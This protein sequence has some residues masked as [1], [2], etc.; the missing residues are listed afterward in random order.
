MSKKVLRQQVRDILAAISAEHL[1]HRS[2]LACQLL[3]DQE[4]YRRAQTLM[5]FLSTTHEVDT[6]QL[7]QRAW[8]DGKTVLAPRVTW[9]QRRMLPIEIQSLGS[10]VEEGYMGI[11]EPAEGMPVPVSELDLVIVPGLAFDEQGNRLGRGRGFYDRF[12]AHPDFRGIACAL[13]LEEQIVPA[14]PVGPGDVAVD[15]LVTDV[16]ARRFRH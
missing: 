10:D 16:R 14:I 2:A 3:C 4:E 13:A 15:M 12:L 8:A 7:A 5:I 6:Q 11:R 1:Q 9:D